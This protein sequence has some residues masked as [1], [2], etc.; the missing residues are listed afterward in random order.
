MVKSLVVLLIRAYQVLFAWVPSSCRYYPS[1]STYA[2]EAI[3]TH[4][5]VRGGWLA[6]RR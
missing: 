4:G 3:E 6:A 2:I 5:M 1:C